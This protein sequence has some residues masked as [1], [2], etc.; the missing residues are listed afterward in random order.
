[1]KFGVR[2]VRLIKQVPDPWISRGS[3][4]LAVTSPAVDHQS[5]NEEY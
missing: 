4:I 5:G 2:H 3:S 1:M